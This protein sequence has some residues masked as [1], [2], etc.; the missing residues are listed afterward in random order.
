MSSSCVYLEK[1]ILLK[2]SLNA[3]LKPNISRQ[4]LAWRDFDGCNGAEYET[5][6]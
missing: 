2:I 1:N 3:M 6:L 4:T 5:L